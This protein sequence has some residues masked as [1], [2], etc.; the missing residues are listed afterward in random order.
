VKIPIIKANGG[1]TINNFLMQFQ[2]NIM[3]LEVQRPV[4]METTA[5]GAAY[6]A[7]LYVK[8][9]QNHE[10]IMKYKKPDIAFQPNMEEE[11]RSELIRNW[12]I[13]VSSTRS[14]KL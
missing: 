12:K 7:G 2:S 10:D 8:Y 14:F 3:D 11:K 4:I 1:A 13:A 9:W 5:L 6:L